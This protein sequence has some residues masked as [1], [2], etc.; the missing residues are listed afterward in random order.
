MDY[1]LNDK[2][3]DLTSFKIALFRRLKKYIE[4]LNTE[5]SFTTM[6]FPE[7]LQEFHTIRPFKVNF[8]M[9]QC[10]SFDAVA[11]NW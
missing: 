9:I 1:L 7:F 10:K 5:T 11:T 8:W 2:F 4:P 6:G 3:S